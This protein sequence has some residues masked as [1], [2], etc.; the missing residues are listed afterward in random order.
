MHKIVVEPFVITSTLQ[1]RPAT[2][3]EKQQIRTETEN[4]SSIFESGLRLNTDH[5]KCALVR[6]HGQMSSLYEM[7]R[8][9]GIYAAIKYYLGRIKAKAKRVINRYI[10]RD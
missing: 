2:R 8:Q 7:I 1:P 9:K 4:L 3:E 6:M 5:L 10:H